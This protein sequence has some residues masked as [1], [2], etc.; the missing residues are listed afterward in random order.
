MFHNW[1]TLYRDQGKNE[2]AIS[3]FL[4]TLAIREDKLVSTHPELAAT[5][6]ELA[7]L[8]QAQGHYHEA[9]I[10]HKRALAVRIQTL[11]A[12]HRETID[13]RERLVALLLSMGRTEEV[14]QLDMLQSKQE[15]M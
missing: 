10:L 2:Q 3:L 12:T 15:E 9:H 6:H 4:R 5:L 8:R 14:A 11:G 13:T 1:A 7:I